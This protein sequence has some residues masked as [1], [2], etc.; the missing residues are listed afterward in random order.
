[1]QEEATDRPAQIERAIADTHL[2]GSQ[3]TPPESVSAALTMIEIRRIHNA[4]TGRFD[5][6]SRR[7]DDY[8]PDSDTSD[9]NSD[10]SDRSSDSSDRSYTACSAEDCGYCGRCQY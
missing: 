8:S 1:M 7:N 2:E 3:D 9:R 5:G 6:W 10:S 4:P